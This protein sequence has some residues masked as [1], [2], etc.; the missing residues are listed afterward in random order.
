MVPTIGPV[1]ASHLTAPDF[2]YIMGDTKLLDKEIKS[3]YHLISGTTNRSIPGRNLRIL[4]KQALKDIF[5]HSISPEKVFEAG[6]SILDRNRET[7]LF[8]LGQTSY[9]PFLRRFMRKEKLKIDLKINNTLPVQIDVHARQE[10]IAIVGMS[11]R[12]PGSD[13]IEGMWESIL[14]RQEFHKKVPDY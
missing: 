9:L 4:V 1:H 10:G 11:G 2:D 5:Q 8:V 12:F 13:S 7:S 14:E 3:N 6:I